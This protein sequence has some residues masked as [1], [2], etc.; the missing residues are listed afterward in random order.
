MRMHVPDS[1]IE[2]GK[3]GRLGDFKGIF[4]PCSLACQENLALREELGAR[5]TANRDEQG[6]VLIE[7]QQHLQVRYLGAHQTHL[8]SWIPAVKQ[9]R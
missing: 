9:Y 6:S 8:T 2:S 3:G 5:Q 7:I 4:S 1:E